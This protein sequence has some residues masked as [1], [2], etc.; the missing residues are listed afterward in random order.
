[1]KQMRRLGPL[2]Q[3]LGMLPGMSQVKLDEH[4]SEQDLKQVE[5][6]ILS[7]TP[8]E[9]R[10]PDIIKQ[11]RRERIAR[12]SGTSLEDV[13]DLIRQFRE[14]QRMMKGMLRGF[15][16]GG[17]GSSKPNNKGGGKK[18]KKKKQH[19]P[20][21]PM[22]GLGLDPRAQPSDLDSMLRRLRGK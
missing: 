17:V 10:N 15:P 1:M 13:G 4:V 22:P 18:G 9:R 20:A 5:A 6:I 14:M 21:R 12:G 16:D 3:I 7:M 19:K 11:S 2:Q 8:E